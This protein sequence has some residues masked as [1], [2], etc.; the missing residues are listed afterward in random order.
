[1]NQGELEKLEGVWTGSER[2]MDSGVPYEAR[3]RL[4]FQLVFD[5]RF[6][7][8]DYVQTVPD[9][10]TAVGHGVFR[11]DDRTSAL[12]VTWFRNP[13]ATPAQQQDAVAEAGSLAFVE[14]IAGRTTR[15]TYSFAM[16]RL[17]IRT[18]AS[19]GG[20]NWKPLLEGT[21]KRR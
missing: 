21:Y 8:C 20:D 18:E 9:R 3:A 1:M 2:I 19:T 13:A 16:D 15:T 12:A 4:V 6:M 17:T 7:L 14:T 5:G 11:R 10:P